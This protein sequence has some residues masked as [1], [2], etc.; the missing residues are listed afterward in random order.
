MDSYYFM[1]SDSRPFYLCF[2][3]KEHKH[4]EIKKKREKKYW[5]IKRPTHVSKLSLDDFSGK[6]KTKGLRKCFKCLAGFDI[7]GQN[8][9]TFVGNKE[10]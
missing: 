6:C 3:I 5:T 4:L 1:H 2:C 8:L 10:H 7:E 9:D